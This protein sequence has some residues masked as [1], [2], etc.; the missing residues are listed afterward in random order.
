MPRRNDRPQIE[1]VDPAD[2]ELL[3]QAA[4]R[5]S[6]NMPT[7]SSVDLWFQDLD[8]ELAACRASTRRRRPAAAGLV[9]GVVAGCGAMRALPESDYA[10]ACEMKRLYVRPAFRRF[11]IGRLLA[12]ALIDDARRGRLFVG[13]A[14]HAR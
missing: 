7:A 9:D 5:S 11:G 2:A 8:A 14:R 10:N 1:L 4:S 3:E 13:A 6:A 12:Q